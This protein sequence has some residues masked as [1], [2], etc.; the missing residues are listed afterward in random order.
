MV[1]VEIVRA[2]LAGLSAGSGGRLCRWL[3]AGWSRWGR[4]GAGSPLPAL[5][6]LPAPLGAGLRSGLRWGQGEQG[7]A[8]LAGLGQ[9]GSGENLRGWSTPHKQ[10]LMRGL[11]SSVAE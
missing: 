11:A 3:S 8:C 5:G 7:L 9:T 10:G 2:V 6:W 4:A 1:V